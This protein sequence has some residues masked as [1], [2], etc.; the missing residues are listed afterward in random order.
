M[1]NNLKAVSIKYGLIIAATGIAVSTITLS[2]GTGMSVSGGV[3][4]V[5][6][7]ILTWLIKITLFGMSHY[8][9]NKKNNGYISFKDAIV[10]GLL[11]IAISHILN[12][13]FSL[14]SYQFFMK[15]TLDS[16]LDGMSGFATSYTQI[17]LTAAFM[18]I[19]VDIVILFVIIT[20]EAHW[21]IFKKAGKEGWAALI[22][23]YSTVVMLDIIKKP[24]I[25]LLFLF[26][27]FINIIFS[28][29]MVNLLAKRFGKDEGY[30]IGLL[31]LPFV[32]YPML[33]LSEEQMLSEDRIDLQY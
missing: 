26:I 1:N 7:S 20:V 4:A 28:I 24:A 32:F 2:L 6:L 21:K 12:L 9:Y 15:E 14:A 33:G 23:I 29:W 17:F 13:V 8:E 19:L 22:P 3:L 5:T 10:I 16:Q 30:T 18:G 27:P 31:F 25:W 11:I